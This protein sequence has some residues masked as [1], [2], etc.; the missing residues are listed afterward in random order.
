MGVQSESRRGEVRGAGAGRE[1][2]D[3]SGFQAG[4]EAPKPLGKGPKPH[5]KC[6]QTL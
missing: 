6:P 4:V 1:I 5:G 3:G 2:R